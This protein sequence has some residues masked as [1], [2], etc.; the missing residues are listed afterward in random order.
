VVV[1]PSID[2]QPVPSDAPPSGGHRSHWYANVG[3][4]SLVHVPGVAV[5]V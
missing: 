3:V 4:V 1:A 2:E 5:S